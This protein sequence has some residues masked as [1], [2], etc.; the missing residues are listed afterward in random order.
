MF[1][2]ST[3]RFV[4]L[5][6]LWYTTSALSSNTGKAIL[7]L[8]RFPVTLTIVQFA[9]IA[10]Y[11]LLLANPWYGTTKLRK[12]TRA[13][14]STTLP[15]AAFQVVGHVF[16]SMAISRIPV[17]TVHTIKALSPLFTVAAYAVLFG[18]KY[19]AKTY[20]SLLPLTLG[21][22]LACSFDIS[23]SN[24]L[25]LLC[26]FG[27][28]VVFVS[29]NIFFKKI[30]PSTNSGSGAN[31]GGAA[32]QHKLDKLNLLFYS[33]GLAFLLM[34]PIWMT[35]DL[36]KLSA[37]WSSE[38]TT[39]APAAH[40]KAG[41]HGVLYYFFA[42]GT[43]HF[44]QNIIAFAILGSTS[45][46]TYSIASLIKRIAV[47]CIAIVW[48]AQRV[49]PVQ[50]FG[51]GM[52]FVGLWMYNEAKGDVERG[53]N[54]VRRIE[55]RK[56]MVLPST[57]AEQKVLEGVSPS[58]TPSPSPSH[59][60]LSSYPVAQTGHAPYSPYSISSSVA[61]SPVHASSM[62]H[63]LPPVN[64]SLPYT[65]HTTYTPYAPYA[66]KAK[67]KEGRDELAQSYPSPPLSNDDSP[68]RSGAGSPVSFA[69]P[70]SASGKKLYNR[71]GT[72]SGVYPGVGGA[73]PVPVV[74][75]AAP[76]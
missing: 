51:I 63:A 11:C 71:R 25:G 7:N 28:A 48:F 35:S 66:Q 13:I 75:V 46:V 17:S 44:A 52:T 9:F 3:I 40:A 16:S 72:V 47:I 42:N 74:A 21:V 38:S 20:I 2:A 4:L 76:S 70:L 68:S 53:E 26:A 62:H 18:V 58:P 24:V 15:M 34:I 50:A 5:C 49:H 32:A 59:Y 12:P 31:G 55:A 14:L 69:P 64:T 37:R 54:R 33:S 73:E 41:S 22:M 67:G 8:F 43:V 29:S 45:P 36:P 27:S 57:K 1:D 56:E 61:R 30:M 6:A 60:P 23:A 65:S 19:T 39:A 10:M